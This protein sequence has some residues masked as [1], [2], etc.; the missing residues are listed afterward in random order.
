VPISVGIAI[1]RYRLYE[2]DRIVNRTLVYGVLTV[3]LGLCHAC[4]S[5]SDLAPLVVMNL[6]SSVPAELKA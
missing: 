1:L 3:V 5:S 4:G 6:G 2:I